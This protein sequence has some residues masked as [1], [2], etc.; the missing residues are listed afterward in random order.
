MP[1]HW[2][3]CLSYLDV[4]L[5]PLPLTSEFPK[6]NQDISRGLLKLH[7]DCLSHSWDIVVTRSVRTNHE[8]M[9]AV[10]RQ[11]VNQAFADIV[12][13]QRHENQ[14]QF[15]ARQRMRESVFSRW[16]CRFRL[17][18][19]MRWSTRHR[20][21]CI[22]TERATSLKSSTSSFKV[23]STNFNSGLCSDSLNPFQ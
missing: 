5:W 1:Q 15:A 21:A 20:W 17:A 16:Y 9:N 18:R 13:L 23:P 7:R 12:W 4:L 8:R 3:G 22:A 6:F 14:W 10:D 2:R 11:P 19:C